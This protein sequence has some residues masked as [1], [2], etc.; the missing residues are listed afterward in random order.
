MEDLVQFIDTQSVS[1]L[2]TIYL[3]MEKYTTQLCR[4]YIFALLIWNKKSF[5]GVIQYYFAETRQLF[6]RNIINFL[7]IFII[8]I[9]V[10]EREQRT[11]N[12]LVV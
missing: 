4:S 6:N 5:Q 7:L 3:K 2:L 8:A 1:S 9:I 10:K 11:V 12:F